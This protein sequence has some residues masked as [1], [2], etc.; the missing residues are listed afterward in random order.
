MSQPSSGG[1]PSHPPVPIL[2][3]KFVDP[4]KYDGEEILLSENDPVTVCSYIAYQ[5]GDWM[6]RNTLARELWQTLFNVAGTRP[7]KIFR[8]FLLDHGVYTPKDRT[9]IAGHLAAIADQERYHAWSDE[10]VESARE[11]STTFDRAIMEIPG[12]LEEIQRRY[13]SPEDRKRME[14]EQ[15]EQRRA[16]KQPRVKESTIARMD[17]LEQ[18]LLDTQ[19]E[20][21]ERISRG[22]GHHHR[23]MPSP[24]GTESVM[25]TPDLRRRD[26]RLSSS[27]AISN[28]SPLPGVTLRGNRQA[29]PLIPPILERERATGWPPRPDPRRLREPGPPLDSPVPPPIYTNPTARQLTDLSKLLTDDMKY[30]GEMYDV[31]DIKLNIFRDTCSKVGIEEH[32]L[33]P[34]FSLLL[35]GKATTFYINRICAAGIRDFPTMVNK[36]YLTEWRDTTFLRIAQDNPTKNKLEI[37]EALIDKLS[38]I[39]RALPQAYQNDEALRS[40]L[41]NACYGVRECE[42]CLFSPAPTLEGVCNQLRSAVSTVLRRNNAPSQYLCDPRD[43]DEDEPNDQYWVDRTYRGQGRYNRFG[44]NQRGPPRANKEI[45]TSNSTG[46]GKRCYV[47][48]RRAAYQRFKNNRHVRDSSSRAYHSFLTA[49]EGSEPLDEDEDDEDIRQYL[50]STTIDD[51][52]EQSGDAFFTSTT[53]LGNAAVNGTVVHQLTKNNPLDQQPTADAATFVLD[54]YSADVFQGILPDTGASNFSTAGHPQA[55]ALQRLQPNATIDTNTAGKAKIRGTITVTTPFGPIDFHVMPTNTPFLL[56]LADMDRLLIRFDNLNNTLQQGKIV[57]PVSLAN[58]HLTDVELRRL[59]RRF[60]HPSVPRLHQ[61]LHEA[62]HEVE[63]QLHGKA[64]SR[65]RFTLRDHCHFNYEVI[66]DVIF[67]RDI[68]AKTTWEALRLCWIDVYQGPPDW[69]IADAGR[70]FASHEFTSDAKAIGTQ[71][72]IVPVEAHNSIGKVERYHANECPDLPR[73]AALQMDGIVPTLLVFGAYPRLT[74]DSPPSPDASEDLRRQRAARQV[75]EALQQRNGPDNL[76]LKDLPLGSKVRVYREKG[77]W[78]GPHQLLSINNETCTVDINGPRDFRSTSVKP[79]YEELELVEELTLPPSHPETDADKGA[80]N[81][82]S[83]NERI[84]DEI[85]VAT[86][87]P[88]RRTG[89]GNRKYA[90]VNFDSRDDDILLQ[91]TDVPHV[92]FLSAKEI[93]DLELAKQLRARGVIRTPGK[94]FE[95]SAKEEI[96]GLIER[97][98]FEVIKYDPDEHKGRIFK[99]R[100]VNEVKGKTTKPYEKSR[101]VVQ[102]YADDGK[103]AILVQ[104][105]TIQRASQRIILAIA[106]SLLR[107]A[108]TQSTSQLNRAIYAYLPVQIRDNYPAGYAGTHWWVTYNRHHREKLDMG[109][110]SFDPCLLLSSIDNADFGL[111]GM[112]TDD[113]IGLTDRRFSER[114]DSELNSAGLL[115]KEKTFLTADESLTFNGGVLAMDPTDNVS[116]TLRQKGQGAKLK[117][118]DKKSPTAIQDYVQQRARG[119]YIASICQPEACFDLSTAAQHKEPNDEAIEALNRRL[120]WQI[121]NLER[122]LR[123]VPLDLTTAKLFVFV[124]GSFA[125]NHDLTSQLGFLILLGT[126]QVNDDEG[127]FTVT[128]N[129]VHFSSTKSKRVTRSVLAS[130]VYGMVAGADMAYAISSTLAMITDKLKTPS[131][132]TIACTDSYSLYE[133]L[134]KLGTTQEKRLMIDIMAL[135]QSYERRELCEI[136]WINGDDNPADGFT[137]TSPNRALERL[138]S[139]NTAT[140][141][142]EGWVTR[143]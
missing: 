13:V 19:K 67:L 37:L 36:T 24:R 106:P 11:N 124:D 95:V 115:A 125:N 59:H 80:A 112:Q 74:T 62:G 103:E 28:P 85:V 90:R 31:L 121:D 102:G 63:C 138:I 99:S 79:F 52:E 34:A 8:D 128:G 55:L 41:L 109:A 58:C 61:V 97:G 73:E 105:P 64:P 76:A 114:E 119:A 6:Q 137:K 77:G 1:L 101:L 5:M 86:A 72:K 53:F 100:I 29:P 65:F 17:L 96:D 129:V 56:C 20:I 84:E 113:T 42:M 89:Q 123:F 135:R 2:M 134:V 111:I 47:C 104:S 132:P 139:D 35:R 93:S 3:E 92:I 141:R 126:E 68:S 14:M 44:N 136:R 108:Y 107:E 118:I 122:G 18:R 21:N 75:N 38:L 69:I 94:P 66:V 7:L 12:F 133:C 140:I 116:I 71:V 78:S 32:Q 4:N 23:E 54:R 142:M 87:P 10:E 27:P 131:I 117:T 57:V 82:Q 81:D 43:E 50:Q 45:D 22:T 9:S 26:T 40:H 110:T 16:E 25:G 91:E 143:T 130:E 83:A 39:Q 30:G 46:N 60:G 49:F 51:V 70:N 127:V 98:V 120:K 33:G 88:P 15:Q 48:Q